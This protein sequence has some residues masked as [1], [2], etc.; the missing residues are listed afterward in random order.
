[1]IEKSDDQIPTDQAGHKR[2]KTPI[3]HV[4]STSHNNALFKSLLIK[5]IY[6]EFSLFFGHFK[7]GIKKTL[8]LTFLL[9]LTIFKSITS[10]Y[11]LVKVERNHLLCVLKIKVYFFLLPYSE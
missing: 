1:M 4:T 3:V 6:F 8:P 9:A 11:F 10:L 7:L 5:Q 2:L